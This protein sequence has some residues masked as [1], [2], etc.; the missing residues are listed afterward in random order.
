MP[1]D[2]QRIQSIFLA[3]LEAADAGRT[4]R[5][6]GPRMRRRCRVASATSRNCSRLSINPAAFS[7]NR[8][9]SLLPPNAPAGQ[10][11]DRDAPSAL[12]ERPGMRMGRYKLLQQIGEGGMGVVYMAEQQEPVRRRVALKIIKPGMDSDARSSPAS[13]PSGKPWP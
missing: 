7:I 1:A 5:P 11:I 12:V 2:P 13:R 6:A 3:A 10:W 4:R 9:C 8:P